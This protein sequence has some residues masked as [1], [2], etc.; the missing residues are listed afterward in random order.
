VGSVSESSQ[1]STLLSIVGLPV[2]LLIPFGAFD[3]CPN[4]SIRVPD[5]CPIFGCFSQMLDRISQRTAL[6]GSCL[7]T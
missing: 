5:L 4:S 3:P 2:R 1:G 6:L 7:Q